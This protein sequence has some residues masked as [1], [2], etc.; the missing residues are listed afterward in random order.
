MEGIN[1]GAYF[2]EV[3]AEEAKPRTK[4]QVIDLLRTEGEKWAGFVEG[5][6]EQALSD[7]ITMPPGGTPPQR[8]RFDMVLSVKEHEMHH[9]AQLM[10]MERMMGIV[11]HLTRQAQERMARM[12]SQQ[13]QR[14]GGS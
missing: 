13:Q 10:L 12:Q 4:A 7:T 11:P 3:A 8:T 6:S 14:Q 9:R 1:F 2:Q 5:I